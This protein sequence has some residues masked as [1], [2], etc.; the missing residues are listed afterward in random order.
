MPHSTPD[1]HCRAQLTELLDELCDRDSLRGYMRDL[2]RTNRLTFAH[3][4]LRH[5]LESLK[6]GLTKLDEPIRVLDVGCGYGD[7]LRRVERWFQSHGIHADLVGLDLSPHTTALAAEATPAIS[8]IEWVNADVFDYT[9]PQPVHLVVSSLFTHHL[10]EAEIVRFL[11]WMERHAQVAWLINDLSRS[12]V[13]WYVF[14]MVSRL[15]RL[16]PFVQ[17]DG[18]ISIARS[19]VPED[20]RRMC[21]SAGI[22][23]RSLRI[24]RFNPGR[25][26]VERR[27][28]Q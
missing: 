11:H 5:W 12:A 25:L 4:P 13:S 23:G 8:R 14:R 27:I 19:F 3:R 2:A 20:W 16:H 26:C 15:A 21:R 18:A 17:R 7:G 22:G 9:P 28:P 6:D 1:F 10:S 24:R